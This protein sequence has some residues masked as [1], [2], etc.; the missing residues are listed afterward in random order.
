MMLGVLVAWIAT[1]AGGRTDEV[2][3]MLT[4]MCVSL[5]H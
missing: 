5:N 4:D 2:S 3:E 1:H